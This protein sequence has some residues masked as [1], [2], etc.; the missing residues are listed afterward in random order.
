MTKQSIKP[1]AAAVG[2]AFAAS[3]A[4]A[5]VAMASTNPFQADQL[6]SGYNL[7]SKHAEGKCGEGT[8]GDDK[9]HA[10]GKCGEGKCGG[11]RASD[12][13]KGSEGKCGEGKCG[14]G[15]CGE[16]KCGGAS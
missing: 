15:K 8:C 7:A 2:V 6:S 9:V 16:G 13:D 1:M 12:H 5:P 11:D 10:E 4:L 3:M 14:E